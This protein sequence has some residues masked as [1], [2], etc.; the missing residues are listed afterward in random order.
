MLEGGCL[1][2]AVRYQYHGKLGQ[3]MACHCQACRKA[4]GTPFVTNMP[5]DASQFDLLQGQDALKE[6][7]SSTGKF[8]VFCSHCG[9]PIYSRLADL[10][11]VLRLRLGTV[12]TPLPVHGIDAHIFVADQANW[13]SICDQAPQY[14]TRP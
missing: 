7:E 10:P 2:G 8:R 5:I 1:C 14:E 12:E 11:N 3:V 6:F 4:Q 13:Y 9:S